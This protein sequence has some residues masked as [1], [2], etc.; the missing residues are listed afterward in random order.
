[1]E[2]EIEILLSKKLVGK[3]IEMSFVENKTHEL[4][5][6][7]MPLKKL[8][9]NT[10]GTDL[11]SIQKYPVNFN[12]Q[13]NFTKWATIEV[14]DFDNVPDNLEKYTLVGGLYAVFIHKGLAS[15]FQKTFQYIFN[16]WLPN[17]EYKIDDREHFEV[18]GAKYSTDDPNSEE[19]VWI[20][21]QL[22]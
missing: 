9:K 20:P 10:V 18:L 13:M 21:V 3:S 2:P 4:W 17:S 7:F 8:I 1:M 5:K 14:A 19:E 6:S 12:P 22:K 11:Y 15:D 16:E